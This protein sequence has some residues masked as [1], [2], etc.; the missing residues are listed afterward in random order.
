VSEKK[1]SWNLVLTAEP[2]SILAAT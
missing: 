1:Q 2:F